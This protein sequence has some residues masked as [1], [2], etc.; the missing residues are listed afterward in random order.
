M[1]PVCGIGRD[2]G[3]PPPGLAIL[4]PAA[5][6]HATAADLRIT[7]ADHLSAVVNSPKYRIP[8]F[9][10]LGGSMR[11]LS[12]GLI[13]PVLPALAALV[14][15]APAVAAGHHAA[16]HV[17]AAHLRHPSPYVPRMPAR[18]RAD[19]ARGNAAAGTQSNT[20]VSTS[21]TDAGTCA[22]SA[23]C[24]TISYAEGQ[25]A[26]AG[27]IHIAA[28]TYNQS[29]DLTQPIH[30]AGAT[31]APVVIDGSNID[32]T[33]NGYY[34]VLGIDNTSGT[35]G[36]ISISHVTVTHP[37]I[38]AGEASLDQSPADIANYDSQ[39][40]D[41]VNVSYTTLGPAQDEADFPG[42]GY[43]SLNAKSAGN[44]THDT[45]KGMFEAYFAEG[46]GPRTVFGNDTATALVS[47]VFSG[48]SYPAVG[49][50]A[51][52]DTSGSLSVSAQHDSFTNYAGWGIAGE[53]GYG[54]GNCTNNVCT[55]GLTLN[56]NYSAFT[57]KAA[58]KG[59]GVA[60]ISLTAALNDA[61]TANLNNSSGT[62]VKP[63]TTVNMQ[64]NGGTM[65]V[66]DSNNTI[67]VT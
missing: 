16:G 54:Q 63:D 52:S 21:G 27:V 11:M 26:I 6:S 37:Y 14:L 17:A 7:P 53:A 9:L 39:A 10:I 22:Q 35:A 12:K 32:Y 50:F 29:A 44:V 19:Q 59:S 67:K 5:A 65:N 56:A 33:K 4:T 18:T 49:L 46:S 66:T 34:G 36:V 62:V 64:D 31:T 2:P 40:G 60:A 23:P 20:Y 41:T 47:G 48:T 55:G 28:G 15:A 30:L 3:Q 58:P 45:A 24:A 25:T 51:L 1:P 8:I 38:T 43:Y 57:L 61:L 13:L 42:L